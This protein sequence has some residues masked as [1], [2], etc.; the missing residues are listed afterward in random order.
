MKHLFELRPW[1]AAD[2]NLAPLVHKSRVLTTRL[3]QPLKLVSNKARKKLRNR[4]TPLTPFH[5]YSH[6]QLHIT[7][8]IKETMLSQ[9][10][11]PETSC[12]SQVSNP[13]GFSSLVMYPKNVKDIY[14]MCTV[15]HHSVSGDS[16]L[17]TTCMST[18]QL[19]VEVINITKWH[20]VNLSS[21]N[22]FMSLWIR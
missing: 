20:P 8:H 5:S 18:K 11:N 22:S 21:F 17:Y 6:R 3:H 1:P 19:Y 12:A 14:E 15:K 13:L 7:H 16:N 9:G 2:L 10:L 4:I